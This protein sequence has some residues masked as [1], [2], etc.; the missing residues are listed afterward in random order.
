VLDVL[1]EIGE[2]DSIDIDIPSDLIE[3]FGVCCRE[4]DLLD[5][6]GLFYDPYRL[7]RLFVGSR[8][9]SNKG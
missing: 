5:E 8:Q 3:S 6:N 9:S 2:K 4:H 7:A 1:I